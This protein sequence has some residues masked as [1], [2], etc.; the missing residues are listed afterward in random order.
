[1]PGILLPLV[2]QHFPFLPYPDLPYDGKTV[3][4]TG[5]N[6]GLGL[7]A[8]R[9]FT[10]LRAERVILAVRNLEKG[11]TAKK[12]IEDSTGRLGVVECWKLDMNSFAGTREFIKKVQTL[13]RLD[14]LILNAGVS[15][16][17]WRLSPDGWEE[18][19]QVNVLST[20]LLALRLLPKMVSSAKKN[21]GW[22]P[23][24]VIVSSNV[25][26]WPS[27]TSQISEWPLLREQGKFG[28]FDILND[29]QKSEKTFMARYELSKLLDIYVT[30]EIAKLSPESAL[31]PTKHMVVVNTLTPGFCMSELGREC[32][33][34]MYFMQMTLA[35]STEKGSRVMLYA[36]SKGEQSHGQYLDSC[37]I[38]E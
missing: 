26:E 2:M 15:A 24:L 12:S 20:A 33:W 17:A 32:G 23:H 6:T 35:R 9:H 7:E 34:D 10:R 31:D 21:P 29:E 14:V 27:V 25:H 16:G 36:S 13:P 8:A 37:K 30:R 22:T 38:V 4:V 5:S 1:M 3:I 11:E 18:T 28:V 19:L